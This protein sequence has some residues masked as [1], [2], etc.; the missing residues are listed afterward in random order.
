M[1]SVA[2]IRPGVEIGAY[3]VVAPIKSGGMASLYVASRRGSDELV[4]LKVP[5][6]HLLDD[7]EFV[8]LF[9]NEGRI[10]L[11]IRHPNVVAVHEVGSFGGVPYLAMEYVAGST[12]ARIR[13][14]V[15]AGDMKLDP[16]LAVW[17][18]AQLASGVH[19]AHEL[20]DEKGAL[21]NVVHRDVSP[22]NVLLSKTG[23]V[24]LTDFGIA[25]AKDLH[26]RG[27]LK[28]KC[29]YMAPEQLRSE[30]LD[31]RADIYA[32][33][34]MLWELLAGR[35]RF[36]GDS[37]AAVIMQ[38]VSG[39]R[40]SVRE[41]V[42]DIDESL[43]AVLLRAMSPDPRARFR[44]AQ[45]FRF[46]LN[47]ALPEALRYSRY[48]L[49][50]LFQRSSATMDRSDIRPRERLPSEDTHEIDDAPTVERDE[51][52]LLGLVDECRH[53]SQNRGTVAATACVTKI[54]AFV[55]LAH[56]DPD[57]V[58]RTHCIGERD[59]S[60]VELDR[61]LTETGDARIYAAVSCALRTVEG[62]QVMYTED[63]DEDLDAAMAEMIADAE[64]IRVDHHK[65]S[66]TIPHSMQSFVTSFHALAV[67]RGRHP[68]MIACFVTYA[69]GARRR[70]LLL[71]HLRD[72]ELCIR[73][74]VS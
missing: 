62:W 21:L 33:G 53:M 25:K 26:T 9:R 8:R 39:E 36:V 42:P 57:D 47:N 41:L 19:A 34:V 31:R 22:H 7:A 72:Y 56:I 52:T 16:A 28:G 45:T 3:H 46:A 49:V 13:D 12:L 48:D 27:T 50:A 68:T 5:H 58:E 11:S 24:K 35:R 23:E 30:P 40:R 6:R 67:T 1:T 60:L 15:I 17:M 70:D 73:A 66:V 44:D 55:A 43:D 61:E 29:A 10:A 4:A 54:G 65:R 32:M 14:E 2:T 71:A 51:P 69:E 38:V 63:L 64:I 74:P 37:D 20:R 18:V 59:V